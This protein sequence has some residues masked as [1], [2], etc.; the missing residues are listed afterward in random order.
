MI[1]IERYCAC[2]TSSLPSFSLSCPLRDHL[3][4]DLESLFV[5]L[6]APAN[7]MLELQWIFLWVVAAIAVEHYRMLFLFPLCLMCLR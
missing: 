7:T 5:R 4:K 6:E 3:I 1:D 2:T